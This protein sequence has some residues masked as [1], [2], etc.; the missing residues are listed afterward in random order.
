MNRELFSGVINKYMSAA[1]EGEELSFNL[2][3]LNFNAIDIKVLESIKLKL[4]AVQSQMDRLL[5][6]DTYHLIGMGKLSGSQLLLLSKAIK[7]VGLSEN[8]IK[9]SLSII[10]SAKAIISSHV[11]D[12][13]YESKELGLTLTISSSF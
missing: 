6:V 8:G 13:T 4:S 3:K 11:V 7:K 1:N 5:K 10:N 9:R 2:K 12:S